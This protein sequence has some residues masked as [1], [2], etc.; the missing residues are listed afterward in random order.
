M[1]QNRKYLP[2]PLHCWDSP[3]PNFQA[4]L[5]CFSLFTLFFGL[6]PSDAPAISIRTDSIFTYFL[7]PP[8]LERLSLRGSHLASLPRPPPELLAGSSFAG[9]L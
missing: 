6:R 2:L 9:E 1:S 4:F 7:P 8:H 5:A 3:N